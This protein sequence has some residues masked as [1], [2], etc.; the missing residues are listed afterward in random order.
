VKP[1]VGDGLLATELGPSSTKVRS[2]TRTVVLGFLTNSG[3]QK[4]WGGFCLCAP[5]QGIGV[6]AVTS[7]LMQST[8]IL[9]HTCPTC[10]VIA[11]LLVHGVGPVKATLEQ[12]IPSNTGSPVCLC[13]TPLLIWA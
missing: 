1:A 3:R 11:F 4:A 6:S 12:K 5:T 7:H 8:D 10:P 13:P 9:L 2:K